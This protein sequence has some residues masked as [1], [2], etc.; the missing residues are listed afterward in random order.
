MDEYLNQPPFSGYE[1]VQ[2]NVFAT[3]EDLTTSPA[4]PELEDVKL[5]NGKY[6]RVRG[7]SRAELLWTGKGTDDPAEIEQRTVSVCMVVPT[8][9]VQQVK[10][11]QESSQAPDLGM[12]TAAI[13]DLSG[14]G[15]GAA[16][17]EVD[18]VR[19]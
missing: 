17:S 9:T 16:K 13:R 10:A 8:M 19:D 3:L 18:Q 1:P 7:L 4:S 14:L 5:A 2:S 12:V 6:V 15:Q 11:W